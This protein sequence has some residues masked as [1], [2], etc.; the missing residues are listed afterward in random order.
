VILDGDTDLQAVLAGA[1][2]ANQPEYHVNYRDWNPQG[3]TTKPA[4]ASG[5]LSSA[6]DVTILA[7]PSVIGTIREV[8]RCSIY[9]KDTASVTVTVKTDDGTTERIVRKDTL[10]T[11]ETLNFE[12][13]RGWYVTT[14]TGAIKGYTSARTPTVQTFTSGSGTY[15]TP[16]GCT[17][18]FVRLVGGG[19]GGAGATANDGSAG[20]NTTFGGL[21][22]NGGAAGL[23]S[24]GGSSAGGSASG[25]DINIPGGGGNTGR[26]AGA[27]YQVG[28]AGGNTVFGGAAADTGANQNG[29]AGATN[30]GGGGS[31]G[32]ANTATT[33][34]GGGG[35]GGYS[36]KL[37]GSPAATYSYGVGA[38][39]SAGAAGTTAGGAGAAGIIIVHEFYT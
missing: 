3:Q 5:A 31:G 8:L 11:L 33:S 30:S 29:A 25:G 15:T 21:T 35:G 36:E 18:I 2:S 27:G 9:N 22:G 26:Q 6:S 10:L 14:A 12:M 34:G 16:T 37:I 32:G 20:G 39:G 4:P 24:A 23:A 19:G 1:V 7:A 17:S 13:G 38:G 28:G